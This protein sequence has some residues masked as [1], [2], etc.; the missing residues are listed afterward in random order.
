G[1]PHAANHHRDNGVNGTDQ[2]VG[3]RLAHPSGV[4]LDDPKD[5]RYL[6]DLTREGNCLFQVTRA[7]SVH[8]PIRVQLVGRVKR[9]HKAPSTLPP[10]RLASMRV[11]R[12]MSYCR[13]DASS[14]KAE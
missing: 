11:R 14:A 10:L 13:G 5:E 1:K 2:I 12:P 8:E 9:P 3:R 4:N 7:R 6:R